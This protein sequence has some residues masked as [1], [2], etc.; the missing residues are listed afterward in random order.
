MLR[1]PRD[2]QVVFDE[3]VKL[4]LGMPA[5]KLEVPAISGYIVDEELARRFPKGS[6]QLLGYLDRMETNSWDWDKV[7]K[8]IDVLMASQL[9][10][11][12]KEKIR[13]IQVR[14]VANVAV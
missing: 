11:A 13:D 2:L 6:A 8:I 1:W 14:R 5:L 3:A 4:T 10:D 12:L 9:D 7:E